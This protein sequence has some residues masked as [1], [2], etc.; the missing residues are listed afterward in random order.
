MDAFSLQTFLNLTE[1]PVVGADLLGTRAAWVWSNTGRRM[2]WANAAAVRFWRAT[3]IDGLMARKAS[4]EASL[5]GQVSRIL[6]QHCVSLASPRLERFRLAQAPGTLSIVLSCR[7]VRYLDARTKALTDGLF[8]TTLETASPDLEQDEGIAKFL[9]SFNA[10]A[11]I[12]FVTSMGTIL[13]ATEDF[14][15]RVREDRTILFEQPLNPEGFTVSRTPVGALDMELLWLH[16]ALTPSN[17]LDK[18]RKDKDK[19][20]DKDKRTPT[21]QANP[22][23]AQTDPPK[24]T[25]QSPGEQSSK[26]HS[27]DD[28]GSGDIAPPDPLPA[29]PST[30]SPASPES[31]SAT[32]ES[33]TRFVWEA[34]KTGKL[35]YVSPELVN[36]VGARSGDIVGLTWPQVA[37]RLELHNRAHVDAIFSKDEVWGR[38]DIVWPVTGSSHPLLASITVSSVYSRAMTFEGYQGLGLLRATPMG[39]DSVDPAD[40]EDVVDPLAPQNDAW[41]P[42]RG[43]K[44]ETTHQEQEAVQA[45]ASSLRRQ[46]P[47]MSVARKARTAG[48][49]RRHKALRVARGARRGQ[50][51]LPQLLV[52]ASAGAG[53]RSLVREPA[54]QK[55]T[56]LPTRATM[57]LRR[58]HARRSAARACVKTSC[59]RPGIA[60]HQALHQRRLGARRRAL[61]QA[62]IVRH[63]RG[64]AGRKIRQPRTLA[65]LPSPQ[66]MRRQGHNRRRTIRARSDRDRTLKPR[67]SAV[68]DARLKAKNGSTFRLEPHV[69]SSTLAQRD[70]VRH[71]AATL[72][73]AS[74]SRLKAEPPHHPAPL[75]SRSRRAFETIAETLGDPS[76]L[77]RVTPAP[78]PG[79][80][81]SGKSETPDTIQASILDKLP[82][83]LIIYRGDDILFVNRQ[84]L[85]ML[86]Y[87][88]ITQLQIRG[89]I[90]AF[91][92]NDGAAATPSSS[93]DTR[94]TVQVTTKSGRNLPVH[95]HLHC[96]HWH[97]QRAVM[98]CLQPQA[99]ALEDD[100]Q[101]DR[102]DIYGTNGDRHARAAIEALRREL[103]DDATHVPLPQSPSTPVP[104]RRRKDREMADA[105][106]SDPKALASILDTATDGVVVLD[107]T[108]HIVAI[109]RSGEALFGFNADELLGESFA[110]IMAPESRR[111]A[112]D[113]LEGL[114]K[115]GLHRVLNDGREIVGIERHGGLIRLFM[116][117]SRIDPAG[118]PEMFCAVLRDITQWK[119]A[120]QELQRAKTRAEE[121]SAQKSDFLAKISHEI[122]TP[123][124]A[125]I[126]FSEVM[127]EERLGPL[128][129]A[130]YLEYLRDINVSGSHLM[131]LVNDLL[132]LSKIEAGRLDLNFVKVDLN[133]V[134]DQCVA[135]MQ[136][137]ASRER[138]IVRTALSSAV[139]PIIVDD[140]SLRQILLN[141]LSNA[142]KFTPAG[143]QIIVTTA[144][145]TSGDVVVR[146]RDTGIGMGD[147]EIKRAL[148]PFAQINS[149]RSGSTPQGTG[150]G[151]PL[152][153]AL[154]EAN[155]AH[156]RIRSEPGRGTIV[157][158]IFP[159]LQASAR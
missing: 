139:S 4:L 130:R 14:R 121:A 22:A 26:A 134:T 105:W 20:K 110:K 39:L 34:D 31:A 78:L 151:L 73:P 132:D 71:T 157:E 129:N 144:L 36:T 6:A 99:R 57:I 21:A 145:E 94:H 135:I 74:P 2:V 95:A 5:P 147:D 17:T 85:S 100:H 27:A 23:P 87:K 10:S 8:C 89:G 49:M 11:P 138:I 153:K 44:D 84:L 70:R 59:R 102:G 76:S 141:L 137:Q 75:D 149:A 142:I 118:G 65:R 9:S 25:A 45:A 46:G 133:A 127:L 128:G 15:S 60:L 98:L 41:R 103:H 115:N 92:K 80:Q 136:P 43:N 146:V 58:G 40:P 69:D 1:I 93:I 109:N 54:G 16:P 114:V 124:N 107:A 106:I 32:T 72:D 50:R 55:R 63:N 112:A 126:G 62:R 82:V 12:G 152:T 33:L 13:G 35:V 97:D 29:P 19:D 7:H 48:A 30:P 122:R 158:V 28:S 150:L 108:G 61:I 143:G 116:T 140:R 155:K 56:P 123:L 90:S 77:D 66:Q 18:E 156:F 3:S 101:H 42:D 79:D 159:V 53:A 125:I 154:I 67:R 119:H 104:A 117:L 131:S 64:L 148:E 96:V 113:Y 111:S 88:D 37:A 47:D 52:S 24:A 81:N 91:M 120:E 83:A 38:F 51:R 68:F 86:E